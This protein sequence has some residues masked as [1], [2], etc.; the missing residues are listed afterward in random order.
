MV[1]MMLIWFR[2]PML[3]LVSEEKKDTKQQDLAI[4]RLV[5]S[6]T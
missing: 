4:M 6:E 2:M 1:P 5:N 3:E